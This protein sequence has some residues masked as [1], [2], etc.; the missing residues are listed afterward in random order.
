MIASTPAAQLL[1]LLCRESCTLCSIL[2]IDDDRIA[3]LLAEPFGHRADDRHA[4]FTDDI[5]DVNDP[6][7]T[8]CLLGKSVVKAHR[9]GRLLSSDCGG[10]ESTLVKIVP[11]STV[12]SKSLGLFTVL[13]SE[14]ESFRGVPG[15]WVSIWV[16]LAI[17]PPLRD[18]P[19][20]VLLDSIVGLPP[21]S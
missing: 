4:W 1:V 18:A 21:R 13:Q 8:G 16:S 7:A 5:T 17:V 12:L 14:S 2:G 20:E 15:F 11:K 6:Q 9:S 19:E 3:S 10:C